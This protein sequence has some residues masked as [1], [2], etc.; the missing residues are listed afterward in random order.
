LAAYGLSFLGLLALRA[1][2]GMFKD[3]KE[4]VYVGPFVAIT[5][6]VA[7]DS[8]WRRGRWG[9]LAAVLVA[10]GLIGFGLAKYG[11]Y[12]RMHT[13]LAGLRFD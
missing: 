13:G 4:F 12:F 8:L 11:E 5:A 7:L 9:R 3:L 10:A 2:S 1:V 6:G